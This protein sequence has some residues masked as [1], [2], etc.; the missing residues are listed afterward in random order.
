MLDLWICHIK[1]DS[2]CLWA[3]FVSNLCIDIF[4]HILFLKE[5]IGKIQYACGLDYIGET[6][7][8]MHTRLI[9]HETYHW[10]PKFNL[11]AV[12]EHAI[13]TITVLT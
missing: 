8:S 11:S 10:L 6:G 13:D 5:G 12:V 1:Y 4:G 7:Q 2:Y 3:W 9:E